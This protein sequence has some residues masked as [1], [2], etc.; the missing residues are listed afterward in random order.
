LSARKRTTSDLRSYGESSNKSQLGNSFYSP[1]KDIKEKDV[2]G[3]FDNHIRNSDSTAGDNQYKVPQKVAR[4]DSSPV[5]KLALGHTQSSDASYNVQ[6]TLLH[7]MNKDATKTKMQGR[8][9]SHTGASPKPKLQMG[10][11]VLIQQNQYNV[12]STDLIINERTINPYY[13]I[14]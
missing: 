9:T 6:N 1:L 12:N 8:K 5:P 2:G 4:K 13:E 7:K 3:I 14:N 11:S 10:Q